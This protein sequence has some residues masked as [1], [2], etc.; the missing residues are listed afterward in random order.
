MVEIYTSPDGDTVEVKVH[1]DGV[2]AIGWVSS[3]HLTQKKVKELTESI[4]RKLQAA[5]L[6]PEDTDASTTKTCNCGRTIDCGTTC[7]NCGCC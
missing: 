2:T 1:K 5:Y 4:D 6:L 3:M 7:T